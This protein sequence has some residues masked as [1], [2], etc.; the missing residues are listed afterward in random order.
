MMSPKESGMKCY[1]LKLWPGSWYI[2]V[3]GS[4]IRDNFAHTM[5]VQYKHVV[6]RHPL[7][8]L[9]CGANNSIL[10]NC[11]KLSLFPEPVTYV[12]LVIFVSFS[13]IHGLS[14]TVGMHLQLEMFVKIAI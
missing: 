3:T 6:P 7:F 10:K 9:S 1:N 8:P 2:C 4:G 5:M 12:R 14:V 13:C 11:A